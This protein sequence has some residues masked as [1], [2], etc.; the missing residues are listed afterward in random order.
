[1]DFKETQQQLIALVRNKMPDHLRHLSW[2]KQELAAQQLYAFKRLLTHAKQH[3]T[4]YK[5]VLKDLDVASFKLEE[6]NQIP[7]T[8]KQ[9]T[10]E[11]W[12]DFIADQVITREQA[13]LHLKNFRD[14]ATDN[15][16]YDN[17]YLL[18]A[19]G[20]SS[21]LRGLFVWSLEDFADLICQVYRY[22]IRDHELKGPG[23]KQAIIVAPTWLHASLPVFVNNPDDTVQVKHFPASMPI[24]EMGKR[25][26]EYQPD[27]LIGYSTVLVELSH[28]AN[29]GDLLHIQ[30][31]Y[32]S[33]NSEPLDESGRDSIRKAW[34]V[35]VNNMWGSVEAGIMGV[36][37][38]R[39]MGMWIS[40]DCCILEPV[41]ENLN[42]V[43]NPDDAKKLLMTG[44]LN[45][46]FPLI[47]YVIDDS[48]SIRE[49]TNHTYR[50]AGDIRARATSWFNYK[51]DI[52]ISPMVFRLPLEEHQ[53][54][55]EFQVEQ[56][57]EGAIIRLVSS[58][59]LDTMVIRDELLGALGNLGLKNAELEIEQVSQIS[60]NEETG[61]IRQFIAYK[62]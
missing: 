42:P 26:E 7:M 2:S 53:E 61:K 30:P 48:V 36:E 3:T 40:D 38:H 34:G 9:D 15:P 6:I 56:T 20:G 57:K 1:M 41:D 47:R 35:E 21:G 13:E 10:L 50:L 54:I 55:D 27:Y 32:I 29:S 60:R 19:T 31:S 23:T 43:S 17:Q 12:N 14:G 39:H 4:Y 18:F 28:L 33:T 11:H 24:K 5:N 25:L 58:N 52:K 49:I 46:T 22:P 59:N 62:E 44:L 45:T 37:D 51:N 8:T 16:F